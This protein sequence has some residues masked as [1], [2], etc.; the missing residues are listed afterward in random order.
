MTDTSTSSNS[1][2][3]YTRHFCSEMSPFR[4]AS[5]VPSSMLAGIGVLIVVTA[6]VRL[7]N[8]L[9]DIPT[10]WCHSE[11]A[12][13]GAPASSLTRVMAC[14]DRP[15]GMLTFLRRP[16]W[17]RRRGRVVRQRGLCGGHLVA[18][19]ISGVNG[20]K[21]Q[22]QTIASG[23]GTERF[24]PSDAPDVRLRAEKMSCTSPSLPSPKMI[25]PL[26]S[27]SYQACEI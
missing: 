1:A 17:R 10:L 4:Q 14:L 18:A 20:M 12:S 11:K 5:R 15:L 25:R 13:T 6:A 24:P 21:R 23:S 3:T 16:S 8:A 27:I 26:M 9:C 7:S 2:C 22:L 19:Y